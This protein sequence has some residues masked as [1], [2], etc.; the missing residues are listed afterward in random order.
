MDRKH[1]D[2]MRVPEID[3]SLHGETYPQ[4]AIM[5]AFRPV[6]RLEFT[7]LFT[8]G[9]V[10]LPGFSAMKRTFQPS[11]V[12]RKRTHGF[13]ARKATRGGRAVINARRAKGRKRLTP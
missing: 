3:F 9:C 4:R 12:R 5:L 13:R 11:N 7:V 8:I 6:Q 2:A 10:P 1:P